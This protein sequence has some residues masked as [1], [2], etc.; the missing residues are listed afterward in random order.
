M[1]WEIHKQIG[2]GS[3]GTVHLVKN[4]E[5][6]IFAALKTMNC[7]DDGHIVHGTLRELFFYNSFESVPNVCRSLGKWKYKDK[8]YILMPLYPCTLETIYSHFHKSIP[9]NDFLRLFLQS[10]RGVREMHAQGFLHRDIKPE[11]ILVDEC[12]SLADFNLMRWAGTPALKPMKE[13]QETKTLESFSFFQSHASS[14][15][16]AS[17]LDHS[18]LFERATTHVCTLWTRAPE[19]VLNLL[20]EDLRCSYS[21]EIDVFSLGSTFLAFASG[22]YV[23]GKQCSLPKN[24]E[25]TESQESK[26]EK[27]ISETKEYKYLYGFLQKFGINADISKFY[28]FPNDLGTTHWDSSPAIIYEYIKEQT[29]WN[30]EQLQF[31]SKLLSEMI[32]PL[33][34]K[35]I[36]LDD[37]EKHLQKELGHA[38]P[39]YSDALL[40]FIERKKQKLLLTKTSLI[41][42]PLAQTPTLLPAQQEFSSL[43][44]WSLCSSNFIPPFIACEIVRIK[45][46]VPLNLQYSKALLY[47]LDMVHEF[48]IAENFKVFSGI[49]I[50]HVFTLCMLVKPKQHTVDLVLKISGTPFLVCCL[51]AEYYVTGDCKNEE[52]LKASKTV[53]LSTIVPFFEAYGTHW[54]SQLSLRQTWSRL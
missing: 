26:A 16:K 41:C 29:L 39:E 27:K 19:L 50:E 25:E 14:K 18:K 30:S 49:D 47:L 33:P 45:H 28:K 43:Q 37:V 32:H 54:K 9:Y 46:F 5:S 12:A 34:S 13:T 51:A 1:E 44:F 11:N 8:A 17:V 40:G 48:Q 42:S 22:D 7:F 2:A 38:R 31:I 20:N 35:R 10:V 15:L 23:L 52:E 21:T 3:Y 4:K 53:H 36:T 6:G 24:T